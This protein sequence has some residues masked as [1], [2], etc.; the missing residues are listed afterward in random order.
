MRAG[1]TKAFGIHF[2][3]ISGIV[4]CKK[5]ARA[6]IIWHGWPALSIRPK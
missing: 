6:I 4:S 1:H 5:A 3:M 2:G